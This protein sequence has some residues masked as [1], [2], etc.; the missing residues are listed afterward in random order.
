MSKRNHHKDNCN[1]HIIICPKFRHKVMI[2]DVKLFLDI[3]FKEIIK[4]YGY[5]LLDLS[6]ENDH[7]H[8]A[9][10][11]SPTY[12]VG[13]VIRNLKSISG[14]YLFKNFPYLRSKYFWNTGFWTN[15]Y[16]VSTVGDISTETILEY[17]K[18]QESYV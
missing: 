12:S 1:Y 2:D 6:I 8:F 16:F 17:I 10:K 13:S 11:L 4:E 3:K 18:N 15:G 5:T 14:Y 7:V 9:L